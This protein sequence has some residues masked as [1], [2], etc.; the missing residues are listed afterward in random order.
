MVA[1][2]SW[3]N[4]RLGRGRD[5]LGRR[6][7]RLGR[8][9]RLWRG[10]NRSRN[11]LG[12]GRHRRSNFLRCGCGHNRAGLLRSCDTA[13]AVTGS[14][15]LGR[16][17]CRNFWAR[18]SLCAGFGRLSRTRFGSLAITMYIEHRHVQSRLSCLGR[19]RGNRSGHCRL[20]IDQSI[21]NLIWEQ[22]E[23]KDCFN[24]YPKKEMPLNRVETLNILLTQTPYK[25]P[26]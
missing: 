6:R 11:R 20:G 22:L 15:C 14:S 21:L 9:H 24:G 12:R 1:Y 10:G 16:G 2:Q 18:Q 17:G 19:R 26:G 7:D 4:N 5:R 23:P 8:G 25:S 3:R 13:W